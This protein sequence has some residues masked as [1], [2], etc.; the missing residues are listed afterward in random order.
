MT[1]DHQLV[2]NS[3][4]GQNCF[5]CG[6]SDLEIVSGIQFKRIEQKPVERSGNAKENRLDDW[7]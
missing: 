1:C 5:W 7:L 3:T 4:K 2:R 6:L